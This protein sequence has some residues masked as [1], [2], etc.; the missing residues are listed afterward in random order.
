MGDHVAEHTCHRV[1]LPPPTELTPCALLGACRRS[2]ISSTML[3]RHRAGLE[4]VLCCP[5]RGPGKERM[6]LWGLLGLPS[7]PASC[8]LCFFLSDMEMLGPPSPG[9]AL[10]LG[11][12][13]AWRLCELSP[14]PHSPTGLRGAPWLAEPSGLSRTKEQARCSRGCGGQAPRCSGFAAA[15]GSGFWSLGRFLSGG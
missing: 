2:C 12:M 9:A 4:A 14:G 3:S 15:R 6:C 10:T 13:V 5:E 8:H 11:E 7:G 1:I